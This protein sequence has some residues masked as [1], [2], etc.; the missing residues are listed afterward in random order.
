MEN[1][2]ER[3]TIYEVAKAS[4]V[5]LATVSRVINNTGTVKEDTKRTVLSVI[6]KLGYKPSGLAQAL[7]TNRTTNIGVIIPSANYVYISNLVNGIT[8]VCKDKG[9]TLLLYTTSHSREDALGCLERVIKSHVDGVIVFDDELNGE[10]LE[11]FNSYGV[12]VIDVN[13]NVIASKIGCIPFGYEHLIKRIIEEN[14]IRGDKKMTFLHVH[15]AGRLLSRVENT[16]IKVHMENDREYNIMNCDDSYNRTYQDF[17]ERFKQKRK[18][19]VIAYRDSIAAAVLNAATDSGLSVPGDVEVLS[20]IGTKY[21]SII[22]PQ[23]TNLHID[24]NE[25]GKTSMYMLI[26][27]INGELEQKVYKFESTY[28]KKDSTRF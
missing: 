19:Y 22:R 17:M 11:V 10:D 1:T 15:N 27:L 28:V 3:V 8:Q 14:F 2:K 23:I 13:N 20:I 24:F 12:P 21:S 25:V 26:D 9:F 4:G 18:E 7:A 5:S 6:K 16:F